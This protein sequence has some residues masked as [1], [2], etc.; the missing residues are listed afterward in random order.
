MQKEVEENE[1][2]LHVL[3]VWGYANDEYEWCSEGT[4]MMEC[5]LL[6]YV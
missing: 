6:E 1:M 4:G 2:E 5:S 3:M